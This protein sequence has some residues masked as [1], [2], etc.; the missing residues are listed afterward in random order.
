MT[1]VVCGNLKDQEWMGR[2][3][4]RLG[5][6]LQALARC[7]HLSMYSSFSAALVEHRTTAE[8]NG[9]RIGNTNSTSRSL[10]PSSSRTDAS[11][12]ERTYTIA[13]PPESN[14]P[15]PDRPALREDFAPLTSTVHIHTRLFSQTPP[16]PR[17]RPSP[18]RTP[19]APF[20]ATA[21][22]GT[23]SPRSR[24]CRW[25]RRR[26]P[27]PT[28]PPSRSR[29]SGRAS[30]SPSTTPLTGYWDYSSSGCGGLGPTSGPTSMG[31]SASCFL[32]VVHIERVRGDGDGTSL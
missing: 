30:T 27:T 15:D 5:S 14:G 12:T 29:S 11:S 13:A 25:R 20:S 10:R 23:S 16:S 22:A 24:S 19:L 7:R 28:G 17:L 1:S 9:Q 32:L 3:Y 26:R 2:G 6:S 18:I 8:S 4:R 21:Y 31:E